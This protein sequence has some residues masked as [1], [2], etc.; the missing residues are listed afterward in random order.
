[1]IGTLIGLARMIDESDAENIPCFGSI[2]SAWIEWDC[3][4]P[5]HE[6]IDDRYPNH[7]CSA[8]VVFDGTTFN[9]S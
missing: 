2:Q 3:V 5:T 9:L 8:Q 6:Y 4:P 7:Q 1:M